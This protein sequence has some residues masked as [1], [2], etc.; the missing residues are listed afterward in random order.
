MLESPNAVI[1]GATLIAVIAAAAILAV[2]L[3]KGAGASGRGSNSFSIDAPEPTAP[4]PLTFPA[5]SPPPKDFT[6][7]QSA[8][9]PVCVRLCDGAF[10]PLSPT[11]GSNDNEKYTSTCAGLCP[12]AATAV[13]LEPNGSDK[14]EDAVST[15]EI[16][17]TAL[18][19]A[20]RFRTTIDSTCTCHREP[21][22]QFP[23]MLDATLRKGDYVMTPRGLMVFTGSKHLP[24]VS[25]DF[26]PLANP[27]LPHD[28]S[29]AL[30]AAEGGGSP[31]TVGASDMIRPR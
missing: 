19:T 22:Q 9:H 7:R 12:D 11:S 29:A 24:H 4:D 5:L 21:A 28:Q 8:S 10:F 31:T 2:L 16:P 13:Y 27:T 3:S 23:I 17:Y 15:K 14:I 1:R 26:A 6:P 18:P 30:V 25:S 20:L